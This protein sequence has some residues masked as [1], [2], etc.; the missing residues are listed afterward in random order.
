[1]RSKLLFIS[2]Y[3]SHFVIDDLKTLQKKYTVEKLILAGKSK[4][5]F[6]KFVNTIEIV[7]AVF[8]NDFVFCWFADFSSFIAI[9]ISKI[10]NKKSIIMV[11]G[12]ETSNLP[13]YGGMQ[14]R[15]AKFIKYAIKNADKVITVSEFLA[16]E[17]R[18]LNL[19]KD[20]NV[21]HLA[22]NPKKNNIAKKKI[23]LSCGSATP[24]LYKIKGID[25]F[26][27]ATKSFNK[28]KMIIVG[29]FDPKLKDQLL[30]K[31]PNLEFKG[32]IV[33]EEFLGLLS[34]TEIYCQ[35]SRRESFGMAVLEAINSNCK[36]VISN[37]GSLPEV[38]QEKAF[39]AEISDIT[40]CEDAISRAVNSE[41]PNNFNWLC[42]NYSFEKREA[43]LIKIVSEL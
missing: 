3:A 23:I 7:F 14:S 30:K 31:N 33:H 2:S 34:E 36:V 39:K 12:Y 42:E 4:N 17:L 35:F 8:R 24:D 32:K 1:M 9:L 16:Q 5:R 11:G 37:E 40:S 22:I 41:V 10:L 29:E 27:A 15:S 25:I 38:A 18:S 43:K 20:I 28:Y 6:Q 21:V 26:A 19:R 13:S